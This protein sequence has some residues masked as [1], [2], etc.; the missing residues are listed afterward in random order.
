[1][2]LKAIVTTTELRGTVSSL[3]PLRIG[4]DEGD[5]PRDTPSRWL[6]VHE[7][8]DDEMLPGVGYRV[9]TRCSLKWPER[10]LLDTFDVRRV[11]LLLCPKLV[12]T[13]GG[14]GLSVGLKIQEIDIE[15]FPQFVDR[16]IARRINARLHA[17]GVEFRWDF[18]DTLTFSFEETSMRSNI[19]KLGFDLDTA[20]LEIGEAGLELGGPMEVRID[21]R[22]PRELER[23]PMAALPSHVSE[24]D[25][26]SEK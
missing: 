20:E 18:S 14:K 16:A 22:P 9:A 26:Q 4:L 17:S 3:L 21:R 25:A 6:D 10:A 24:N 19:T 7:L 2:Q 5:G 23:E 12:S 11:D 15:W 13:P 1:M 8:L